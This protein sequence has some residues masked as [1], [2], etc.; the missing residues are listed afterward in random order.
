M[1]KI[2]DDAKKIEVEGST[3]DFFEFNLGEDVYFAFDTSR[4]GPPDPMVNAMA[5]LRL[6]DAANK[7]L[8][9][10]NHKSPGGLFSKIGDDFESIVTEREDGLVEIVFS[11]KG[12]VDLND[13]KY[14]S[15]CH[16]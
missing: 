9:M 10:I 13:P 1:I 15:S 14:C 11:F 6:L 3:V 8:L 2:P 4:C 12:D 16:G 5:G 7:K